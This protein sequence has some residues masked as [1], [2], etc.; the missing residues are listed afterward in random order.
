MGPWLID[1]Q[2]R[3]EL[4]PWL[5]DDPPTDYRP[6]VMLVRGDGELVREFIPNALD[7]A[8]LD[9]RRVVTW[10]KQGDMFTEKELDVY[11]LSDDQILAAV[12]SEDHD[13]KG[14]VYRD[15]IGVDDAAFAFAKAQG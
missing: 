9:G 8:K 1:V 14:W 13:V 2:Y 7:A 15:R 6:V 4:E 10:I 11:F 12:L 5:G 3:E